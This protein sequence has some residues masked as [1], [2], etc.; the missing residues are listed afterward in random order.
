MRL[1]TRLSKLCKRKV[2]FEQR[3]LLSDSLPTADLLHS[4][5]I[6]PDVLQDDVD[7]DLQSVL[8]RFDPD[9]LLQMDE[10][11]KAG[12]WHGHKI[13]TLNENM[14]WALY[15]E[16]F[17]TC[18][19]D[20]D[21]TK[22]YM[23]RALKFLAGVAFKGGM[24]LFVSTNRQTMHL[25]ERKAAEIGEFAHTRYWEPGTLT[26]IK[27]LFNAPLRLP[28]VVIFLTTLCSALE[29]HP[30]IVEAAK[31]AIPTIGICDTN[32]EPN[33][34]T[35]PIPGDDDS[36]RAVEFYMNVFT[37]AVLFGKKARENSTANSSA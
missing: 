18:I 33:Y 24:I 35:Y 27:Q 30:G 36:T 19:I 31:M 2:A 3:R 26:N 12:L 22:T 13:G 5:T 1:A 14:K 29:K 37:K 23:S 10:M 9:R 20:L 8:R 34:L 28:D 15:G 21:V 25:V 4:S 16:R 6:R 17:G 32:S 7:N 11:F